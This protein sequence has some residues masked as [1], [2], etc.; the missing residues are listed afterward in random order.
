[1]I[2]KNV[3]IIVISPRIRARRRSDG[4]ISRRLRGL[5]GRFAGGDGVTF[6]VPSLP[7]SSPNDAV[8]LVE[9]PVHGEDV[10][11]VGLAASSAC[12]TWLVIMRQ[13]HDPAVGQAAGPASA[14]PEIRASEQARYL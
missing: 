7:I 8:S 11:C 1:M 14:E 3:T 5:T 13:R 10:A 4:L 2:A 6:S 12:H 9:Q